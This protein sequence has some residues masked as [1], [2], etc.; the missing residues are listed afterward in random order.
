M[1]DLDD[2][3]EDAQFASPDSKE[4]SR[5][6]KVLDDYDNTPP[7]KAERMGEADYEPP[8]QEVKQYA[9]QGRFRLGNA[10][11]AA[12]DAALGR[13]FRRKKDVEDKNDETPDAPVSE[14]IAA[15]EN[16]ERTERRAER[17]K[18]KEE[19]RAKYEEDL[20]EWEA[21]LR[22]NREEHEVLQLS[23]DDSDMRPKPR[24]EEREDEQDSES[25]DERDRKSNS[26]FQKHNWKEPSH[27]TLTDAPHD[28]SGTSHSD[29]PR[30]PPLQL[31]YGAQSQPPRDMP[32]GGM[33]L[34]DMGVVPEKGPRQSAAEIAK[35]YAERA[36]GPSGSA[37]HA[38]ASGG[39][40]GL[41]P[42]MAGGMPHLNLQYANQSAPPMDSYTHPQPPVPS[43]P[44]SNPQYYE[45]SQ[46]GWQNQAQAPSQY[47]QPQYGPQRTT[48]WPLPQSNTYVDP[49]LAA[50][51]RRGRELA[52]LGLE[53]DEQGNMGAAKE[54][55]MKAL[56]LMIPAIGELE[57]GNEVSRSF[58]MTEKKKLS[59]EANLLLDRCENIKR[60]ITL[61]AA[62][63]PNVKPKTVPTD[64]DSNLGMS[65]D[66]TDDV[67]TSN[68][69]EHEP[70]RPMPPNPK[71]KPLPP[72]RADT[73]FAS[74]SQALEA[75]AQA[76]SGRADVPENTPQ[77]TTENPPQLPPGRPASHSRPPPS[78]PR[79]PPERP[80]RDHLDNNFSD[81][82]AQMR[83]KGDREDA[84]RSVP[85]PPPEL[86]SSPA[87]LRDE[88][89]SGGPCA[90]STCNGE[91][92][93][94]SKCGHSFCASCRNRAAVVERCLAPGC[95]E[96]LGSKDFRHIL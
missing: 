3:P 53:Q 41:E 15:P 77:T 80:G 74:L 10:K 36:Y 87:E 90:V 34:H 2:E 39:R 73:Q 82:F 18:R 16:A 55:Y 12:L 9:K 13:F 5:S 19:R 88:H 42:T 30:M 20:K 52:K 93:L 24:W 21:E 1:R 17:K 44:A 25:E 66:S 61:N 11:P 33:S 46:P 65:T 70:V 84:L 75:R 49:S 94:I 68:G 57:N 28:Y 76:H 56:E 40:P 85:P 43:A 31:P 54:A 47:V 7:V 29:P 14:P 37:S 86:P 89:V 60:L 22:R 45:Y 27:N 35:Q 69:S 64:I 50:K 95:S 4:L 38:A 79:P 91:T 81:Q 71:L 83:M 48:Q 23:Y 32:M 96:R 59:K 92:S 58:R 62:S 8:P 51:I 67:Y 6:V 26:A 63:V 72:P 78:P